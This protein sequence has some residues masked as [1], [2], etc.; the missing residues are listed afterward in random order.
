VSAQYR[1]GKR[2]WSAEDDA[3]LRAEYPDTPTQVLAARLR[4]TTKAVYARAK[5]MGLHKSEAYLA[6]PAA[7]RLRRGGDVGKATRFVKGQAPAN[8]GLRRPGW[9]RG[10]MRETQFKPGER[11]GVAA[12]NYRP[13]GTIAPDPEGYL[14]IKVRDAAPREATGFGNVRVWPMLQRHVWEQAHGPI[15]PN[16]A[17]CFKDGD[18]QNC[19]LDNLELVSRADLMKRNSVHRLP[20]ELAQTIQLL[21]AL[22]RQIRR[23]TRGEEQDQR[24]A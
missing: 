24:P 17:V 19:A 13:I 15:P 20:P 18:R 7:C 1:A 23:R 5:G 6:S 21:G 3:R 9:A 14:R 12:T 10:R 4:R 8:K 22:K 16:H 2:L 11:R